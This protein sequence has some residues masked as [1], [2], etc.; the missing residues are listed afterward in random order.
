MKSSFLRRVV[1]LFW[2]IA[3]I[4]SFSSSAFAKEMDWDKELAKGYAELSIGNKEKALEYFA[5]K[6]S[7]YPSSGACHTALG[8]TYKRLGKLDEAK[9]E[10]RS[11]VS[12]EPGFA[13]GHY[14][15]GAS[16]ESDQQYSE[17]VR[18][19]QQYLSLSPD[20]SKRKN[21]EDRIRFCQD[22][23]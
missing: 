8:R 11:A 7:K 16:L 21:I 9:K 10:F 6:V 23:L 18:C 17:A 13:D 3:V 15:L 5:K 4:V 1:A 14:E 12:S 19:F 2:L 20:A 22:K